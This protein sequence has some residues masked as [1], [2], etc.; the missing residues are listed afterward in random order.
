MKKIKYIILGLLIINTSCKKSFFDIN[1]NPNTPTA[2][3]V[4]LVLPAALNSTAATVSSG[5]EFSNY[6]MGYWAVSGGYAPDIVTTSYK[7]S[8]SY[9][10]GIWSGLYYSINNYNYVEQTA[11][12][13]KS[14]F[15]AG[16]AKIMKAYCYHDLVDIYGNV[17]YSQALQISAYPRP[18]YDDASAIY[19]NLFKQIDSARTLIANWGGDVPVATSD[20]MFKGS[21]SLWLKF[22]NTLELRMLLRLSQMATKPSYY[23]TEL[24]IVKADPNGFLGAGQGAL[25]NPGYSNASDAN[26]NPFYATYGYSA[27]GTVSTNYGYYRANSYAINFYQIT[28]DP[29]IGKFYAPYS[30]SNFAGNDYGVQGQPNNVTS[31]IGFGLI[32]AP[33]QS[34]PVLTSFE[35]LFLQAEAANRGLITG[36]YKA[37][38][39][40]AVTE[41]FAYFG[42]SSTAAQT[43]YSQTGTT[44]LQDK[45]NIDLSSN[46]ITTIMTQKWASINVI[47]PLEPYADWRR[48]KIP[49]D[50]PGSKAVGVGPIPVRLYYPLSESQ[51]N[52]DNVNAQG[53]ITLSTKI[54]WMP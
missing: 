38:Y 18:A 54:F 43:Y 52:P 24:A 47:N 3:S 17:P 53:T 13:Q 39:K 26:L 42:L 31:G 36:D 50:A 21:A 2:A 44:S 12:A 27:A 51:T 49:A 11:L 5:L 33:S 20:I 34:A 28:S 9:Y 32:N 48:V 30:G 6:W 15:Y 8:N 41:A 40:S 14:N 10:Q 16:I 23:A 4:D 37:L 29:R 1:T 45:V 46:A 22:A 25:V 19:G 35:S 7:F